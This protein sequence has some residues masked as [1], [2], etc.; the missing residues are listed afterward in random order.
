MEFHVYATDGGY[1]VLEY[2]GYGCQYV[3]TYK[4]RNALAFAIGT[5][6]ANFP[7]S[8]FVLRDE[9]VDEFVPLAM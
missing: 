5:L 1:E 9:S 8:R 4:T 7:G 2:D 3:G 6:E